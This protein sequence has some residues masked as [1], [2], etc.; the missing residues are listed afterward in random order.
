MSG[1]D[2]VEPVR[3]RLAR[4]T[5]LERRTVAEALEQALTQAGLPIPEVTP[6]QMTVVLRQVLP[7]VLRR[8]GMADPGPAC[9]HLAE[10]LHDLISRSDVLPTE[11]AYDVFRRLGGD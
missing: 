7:V 3:E 10:E 1:A 6:H 9:R 4:A 11:S 8:H 2:L 5:G